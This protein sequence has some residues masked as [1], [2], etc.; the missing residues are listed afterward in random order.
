[1]VELKAEIYRQNC[2]IVCEFA[3]RKGDMHVHSKEFV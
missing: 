3:R 2:L 1:M